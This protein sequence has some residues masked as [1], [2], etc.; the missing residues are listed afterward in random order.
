MA[1]VIPIFGVPLKITQHKLG[2]WEW[3]KSHQMEME[4]YKSSL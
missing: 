3:G 4:I 2:F 1:I